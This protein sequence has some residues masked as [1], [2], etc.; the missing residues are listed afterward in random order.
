M[1]KGARGKVVS[2]RGSGHGPAP[3][4]ARVR[5]A[6][7]SRN[8][9]KRRGRAVERPL[10]RCIGLEP[11]WALG[12][13]YAED[14]WKRIATAQQALAKQGQHWLTDSD[15]A[16]L[17]GYCVKVSLFRKAWESYVDSVGHLKQG[18][19]QAMVEA[20]MSEAEATAKVA[21]VKGI[22]I[23]DETG[24]RI[25]SPFPLAVLRYSE[26][27]SKA[28]LRLGLTFK[29]RL[30]LVNHDEGDGDGVQHGSD[31]GGA[32]PLVG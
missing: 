28:A 1:A 13:D 12:E 25:E 7:G 16:E 3:Q 29:T 21:K 14:E 27:A 26:A 19:L 31:G 5:M 2:I 22:V 18:Q 32:R 23:A 11:P 20:G 9:S 30:V 17:V 6:K 4:S 24:R 10:G 8:E 15:A